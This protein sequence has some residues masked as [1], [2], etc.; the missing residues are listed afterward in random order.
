MSNGEE[1]GPS[2]ADINF[3]RTDSP[4]EVNTS[5]VESESKRDEVLGKI[6][7]L[8]K[9]HDEESWQRGKAELISERLNELLEESQPARISLMDKAVHQGFIHPD[10][11]V[12]RSLMVD[13]FRVDDPEIYSQ[14]LD[15]MRKMQH[16][17][18]KERSTRELV[19]T[20]V[21]LTVGG[22]FGNYVGGVEQRNRQFYTN[23]L[24]D[25]VDYI[26]LSEFKG[27]R[28]GVCVEKATVTQN[29]LS[30]LGYQS[31]LVASTGNQ[32][33]ETPQVNQD[34]HMYNVVSSERGHFIFDSTNP[35][36]VIN[37]DNK[38]VNVSPATYPISEQEYSDLMR[39]GKVEVTHTNLH[40]NGTE[41]AP[42]ESSTRVYAGP[43][44]I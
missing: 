19:P 17:S 37:Q 39:G 41:T 7:N 26:S 25:E 16:S 35:V 21:E 1:P 30:F 34:A 27:Q 24:D 12:Y 18:W 4:G 31:E 10:S 5:K 43:K 6:N 20:A 29:L 8:L 32:F 11:N 23:K 40:W 38:L 13:P 3:Q 15:N 36:E 33:G 44:D 28:I 42:L 2:Q 9:E 14:L 22:Y